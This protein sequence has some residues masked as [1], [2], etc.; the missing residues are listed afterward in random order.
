MFTT[1]IVANA[2]GNGVLV[3]TDGE[4]IGLFLKSSNIQKEQNTLTAVSISELKDIIELLSNGVSIPYI[5]IKGSTVTDAISKEYD[6]P[7]GVYVKE[8]VVDSPAMTAGLQTG[9]VIVAVNK[10]EVLSMDDYQ[11]ILLRLQKGDEVKIT[12]NRQNAQGYKKFT[13]AV[14]VGVLK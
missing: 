11:Q 4:V 14:E 6:I 9:D 7:K 10:E 8:A 1:N 13:C 3:N 12:A 2:K 5:G